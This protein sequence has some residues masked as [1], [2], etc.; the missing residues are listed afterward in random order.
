MRFLKGVVDF[1]NITGD[2]WTANHQHFLSVVVYGISSDFK[3]HLVLPSPLA[4]LGL[5]G[6]GDD[7][8]V[9]RVFESVSALPRKRIAV[10]TTD[11]EINMITKGMR[12]GGIGRW[13]C[14]AAVHMLNRVIKIIM[15][16]EN[17]NSSVNLLPRVLRGSAK[18]N[19]ALQK[20]MEERKRN[21]ED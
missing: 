13:P 17:N 10:A 14:A 2:S 11:N 6:S 16:R 15:K 1:V 19:P 12:D 18:F 21:K 20:E 8:V 9:R 3:N 5:L 7:V 4:K